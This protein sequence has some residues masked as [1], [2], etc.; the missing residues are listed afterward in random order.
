MASNQHSCF[1]IKYET[2]AMSR[3]SQEKNYTVQRALSKQAGG[4]LGVSLIRA[5]SLFFCLSADTSLL[6]SGHGHRRFQKS[7]LGEKCKTKK[8]VA[9]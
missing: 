4:C 2:T 1:K 7:L 5:S 8:S 6:L 3:W 9:H